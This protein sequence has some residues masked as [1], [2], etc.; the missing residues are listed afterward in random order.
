MRRNSTRNVFILVSRIRNFGNISFIFPSSIF[1]SYFH[2]YMSLMHWTSVRFNGVA[3][4]SHNAGFDCIVVIYIY[5]VFA[6]KTTIDLALYASEFIVMIK[7]FSDKFK[8]IY[9]RPL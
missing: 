9:E 1:Y 6:F 4:F 7:K 2:S 8:Y 3:V 5:F